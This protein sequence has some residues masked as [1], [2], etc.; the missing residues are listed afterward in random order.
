MNIQIVIA[1]ECKF[2]RMIPRISGEGSAR[3]QDSLY[4]LMVCCTLNIIVY[5]SVYALVALLNQALLLHTSL[6]FS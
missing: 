5:A 1:R 2:F 3:L 6:T 4:W